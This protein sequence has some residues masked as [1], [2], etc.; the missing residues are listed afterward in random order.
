ML[1]TSLDAKL[2][3]E[4][5]HFK[6]IEGY[7]KRIAV[8]ARIDFKGKG[9]EKRPETWACNQVGFVRTC[10][11]QLKAAKK[12]GI[13]GV[14][15]T[16]GFGLRIKNRDGSLTRIDDPRFDPFWKTCGELELPVLIHTADP[17]AFFKPIDAN[18][19]R[20]E[21]LSRHP[22]WSFHGDKFPSREALFEARNRVIAKHPNTT[23][24]GAHFGGN[25]EDLATVGKWLDKYP[26]LVVEFASRINELGRQ[27]YS[28]RKFIIKYLS[29]IH[30]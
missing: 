14:K 4:E 19:E 21:E 20:W 15:F 11:E 6:F 30:I 2:G 13:A 22:D 18:N 26:N 16:K 25:S 29:L 23:F 12:K 8:F 27:P 9:I 7:E 17:S 5:E 1:T 3:N 24:I 10:V 28:A